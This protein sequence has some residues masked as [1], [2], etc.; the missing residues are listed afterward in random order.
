MPSQPTESPTRLG[1][2]QFLNTKPLVHAFEAGLIEHP[3]ELI[4]DVPSEC[5]RKLHAGET[6]VALIP[7]IEIGRGP[8][9]YSVVKGVGIGSVGP[10]NSVFLVL[11]KDPENVGSVALDTSS[12]S[13]VA[14]TRILFE[15]KFGTSPQTFDHAPDVDGMLAVADAAVLIGD[16]A[17]ELDRTRYRVLDL[18]QVWTE[19]T[20]LP[21][22]YA[23]WTGRVNA[24]SRG[25]QDLLVAAK[26][27]GIG[28]IAEIAAA[29]AEGRPFLPAFYAAYLTE[30]IQFDFGA[31][32]LEGMRCFFSY[33]AELGLIDEAPDI[34]FYT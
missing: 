33:A 9:P 32:E 17:L 21:F 4:Y 29:Y 15:K 23:C 3:F 18:G 31:A 20:G 1:V 12:R 16:I 27:E 11:N 30:S 8:E 26:S 10:V 28:R 6:D 25:E 7:A 5:A 24:I 34:R 14:L 19:W 22:V 13:S 2:V